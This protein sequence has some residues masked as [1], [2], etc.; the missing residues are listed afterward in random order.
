MVA[1]A[2]TAVIVDRPCLSVGAEK[3]I[4]RGVHDFLN[5]VPRPKFDFSLAHGVVRNEVLLEARGENSKEQE[6]EQIS[7]MVAPFR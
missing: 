7:V 2:V 3:Q 5:L 6:Q 1:F 4:G